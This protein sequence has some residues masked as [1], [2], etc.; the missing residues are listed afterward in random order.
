MRPISAKQRQILEYIRECTVQQGYPSSVREIA[1]AV[2]LR[3]PSSVHAHLKHLRELGYL[4]QEDGKTRTIQ[5]AGHTNATEVPLLG[6]VAAGMP[7]LA[8][9]EAE[10]MLHV[11]LD[12]KYGK[13]FA[14]RIRGDS[15][16]NAGILDGDFIIVRSQDYGQQGQ[17]VVAMLEDEATC[18][19][20]EKKNGHIWLMPENPD[21]D[22]I[23]GDYARVIGV[24]VKVIRDYPV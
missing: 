14:L 10:R 15:M 17:I 8:V 18:K 19:R 11:D 3:S 24:V 9:E 1:A 5:L 21:Y 22:P 16:V 2:G 20:L 23:P 4:E 12:G 13:F 6:R 7:I